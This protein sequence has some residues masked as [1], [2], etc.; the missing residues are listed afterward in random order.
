[1]TDPRFDAF[2]DEISRSFIER[3]ITLWRDRVIYPF[4][5][6]TSAGP[7]VLHNDDELR[8]NFELY[9][10]ASDIMGL[11]QI[12]RHPVSLEDCGDGTWIG[13]Y[14][15]ELLSRGKRAAAPYTSSALL[16]DENGRFKM[17]SILNARGHHYWTAKRP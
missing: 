8:R 14:V 1:M 11:D 16:V 6:I 7:V 15:T 3:D 17:R 12:V 9:L 13:T 4:S 10:K 5:L 2:L